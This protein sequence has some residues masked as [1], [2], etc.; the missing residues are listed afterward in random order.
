MKIKIY[1]SATLK[2]KY[3]ETTCFD[4]LVRNVSG[5]HV[6]LLTND[7]GMVRI[8]CVDIQQIESSNIL[9]IIKVLSNMK[10][11]MYWSKLRF[12]QTKYRRVKNENN[13]LLSH[14]GKVR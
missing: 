7:W 2:E 12:Y 5:T 9:N 3:F 14:G 1:E 6:E 13:S 10:I 8:P 4:G 11:L